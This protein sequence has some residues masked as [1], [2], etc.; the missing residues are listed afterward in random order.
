MLLS[1]KT[2]YDFLIVGLGNPGDK[3]SKTRHNA[4]FRAIDKLIDDVA[5]GNEKKKFD[6]VI[7]DGQIADKKVLIIKP[8]TFMNNSGKAVSQVVRFYKIP[9]DKIIVISDDVSMDAG[10]LR[11][12]SKGSD[13]GQK[14]L[15]DIIELLGTD[16]IIRIKV[17]VGQK[18]HPDYDLAD[19]VLGKPSKEDEEKISL[20]E[21]DAAAAA[22]LIIS[23]SIN[24]AM[25]KYNR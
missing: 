19:W 6:A 25:S 1:K 18:P 8:Q 23:K 5:V 12:R 2:K 21:A 7:I 9:T 22:K 24:D 10:R 3:Y 15:R 16:E 14:G 11:I 20:S 13:G 17:G 4:G